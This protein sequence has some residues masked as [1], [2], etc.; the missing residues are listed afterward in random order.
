MKPELKLLIIF[1]I[2][3][4]LF[5]CTNYNEAPEYPT[6]AEKADHA[7]PN[8]PATDVNQSATGGDK[9]P[10]KGVLL[11]VDPSSFDRI[12]AVLNQRDDINELT[13]SP[14]NSIVAFALE[15]DPWWKMPV[16]LWKVGEKKPNRLHGVEG[17]PVFVW[18][19][20]SKYLFVSTGT[21][22]LRHGVV[23][24]VE[25]QK[26]LLSTSTVSD[27][28]WSPDS[29]WAALGIPSDIKADAVV[30]LENTIDLAL[31]NSATGKLTT[32]AKAK[33]NFYYQ[34]DHW[35]G[36]TLHF[37]RYYYSQLEG[38]TPEPEKMSYELNET[39]KFLLETSDPEET[40]FSQYI[41]AMD[42]TTGEKFYNMQDGTIKQLD[43]QYETFI[44][45][46]A[47]FKDSSAIILD[48]TTILDLETWETHKI[49]LPTGTI[50]IGSKPSPDGSKIA[51]FT[52]Q[53]SEGT[54][55]NKGISLD[56]L[57]TN[58][59]GTV[60]KTIKTSILPFYNDNLQCPMPLEFDWM[61][62][63][64]TI[65]TESWDQ[66]KISAD[67]Y[68]IQL[69]TGEQRKLLADA[70]F[71]VVS[72]DG[73]K[74]AVSLME[75]PGKYP[76]NTQIMV[77]DR[78]GKP[79]YTLSSKHVKG[80]TAFIPGVVYWNDQS[81]R[82]YAGAYCDEQKENNRSLIEWNLAGATTIELAK[83]FD[84]ILSMDQNRILY[85]EYKK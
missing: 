49:E 65:I 78:A 81:N 76:R 28:I 23:I 52:Y 55:E 61:A 58:R 53:P 16:Y 68:S 70:R 19:P 73:A 24:E 13:W 17:P 54:T 48:F 2:I 37:T 45:S 33:S 9:P 34:S 15:N 18:A 85:V 22:V 42:I 31:L 62:D 5:G 82:I 11:Q 3:T 10:E 71:P 26:Q 75:R 12:N 80:V 39:N 25:N 63:G 47:W 57:I 21:F 60:I 79:L 20:N 4:F 84:H 77:I 66:E 64:D 59:E 67:I 35:E 6:Q 51:L 74:V 56:L 27:A 83:Y 38:I 8:Y 41:Y 32:I 1:L 36:N 72:P 50:P 7:E 29:N 69:S 43:E 46:S 30:D 40:P 14:D 44:W